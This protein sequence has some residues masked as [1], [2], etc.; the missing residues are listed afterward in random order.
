Q[1]FSQVNEL[2][3]A[4]TLYEQAI[5]SAECGHYVQVQA[6]ALTGI[7]VLNRN[8]GD[9][10]QAIAHHTQSIDLF[11]TIGATCD[12]AEA[13]LQ[14]SLSLIHSDAGKDIDHTAYCDQSVAMFSRI[15]APKQIQ[16]VRRVL[17]NAAAIT[18]QSD[19]V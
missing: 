7:A 5:K 10:A 15:S 14:F 1:A 4:Q 6:K 17:V 18:T 9:F 11:K 2:E 13:Y 16:R 8:K 19:T 3:R 12:L